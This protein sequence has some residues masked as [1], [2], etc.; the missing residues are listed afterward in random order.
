MS[1]KYVYLDSSAFAKLVMIEPESS[2]LSSFLQSRPL[3]AAATLLRTEVLRA[4]LRVSQA[5][6]ARA[7]QLL[8]TV[9]FIDLDRFLLDHAG[10][11]LPPD[12]RSLD[13]VHLA[14]ALA[15]GDDLGEFVTYDRRLE[16]AANQWGLAV[17]SPA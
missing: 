7:R 2:A 12:I 13:A 8:T 1:V 9:A 3:Q 17:L 5:H 14:A 16:A 6:V 4:A 10:T 15:L 11:L